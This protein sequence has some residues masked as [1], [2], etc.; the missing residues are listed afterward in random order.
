[1]KKKIALVSAFM[2]LLLASCQST[3]TASSNTSVEN[4]T[5]S[6][7]SNTSASD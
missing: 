1:M 4:S 5:V 6:T 2:L 3:G 7:S